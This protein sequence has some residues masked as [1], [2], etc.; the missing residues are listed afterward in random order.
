MKYYS[1]SKI[2]GGFEKYAKL[3][4]HH[5]ISSVERR[6]EMQLSNLQHDVGD[7]GDTERTL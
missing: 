1:N 4:H 2:E 3:I 6:Q 7:E 5:F